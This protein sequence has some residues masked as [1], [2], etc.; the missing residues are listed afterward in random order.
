M[1]ILSR[2]KKSFF[3][4]DNTVNVNS[5]FSSEINR[6]MVYCKLTKAEYKVFSIY[7]YRG[8]TSY[9]SFYKYVL[10]NNMRKIRKI[11][12]DVTL[13]ARNGCNIDSTY[14]RFKLDNI[15]YID[16]PFDVFSEKKNMPLSRRNTKLWNKNNIIRIIR[17]D[18]NIRHLDD[19]MIKESITNLIIMSLEK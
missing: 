15:K 12:K 2:L 7:Y 4:S 13:K 8:H 14:I 1:G 6:C 11:M 16:I 5:S 3:S 19:A 18:P 9:R 10:L 17:N